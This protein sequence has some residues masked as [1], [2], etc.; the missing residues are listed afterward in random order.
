MQTVAWDQRFGR[1]VFFKAAYLHRNGSHASHRRS[2]S[3][4]RRAHA[5]VDGE[6]KYWELETTGR[7]LA[8]EYRDLTVSY[9]RSHSTRDLNDYDQ[10]F[11][12]FRNP[13][14]RAERELAQPDRRAQPD[15]R[16]RH[17]GPAGKW[18]FSP[19]Y[20]W[21]IGFPVVGR[22]RVSGFRRRAESGRPAAD[23]VDARLLAGPAVEVQEVP[24]QRRHQG[25]QHLQRQG[26]RDVQNN[27]TSPDYGTFY[28]PMQ[29]SIGFAFGSSK[30]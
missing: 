30:P 26:L 21:R 1:R 17:L 8:S 23:R 27:V 7:Y 2:R 20:E 19:L 22:G 4:P 6:S 24:L 14:I 29:R 11:G 15:H 3:R 12:N 18:V 9:V 5:V 13:I 25:L 28:N 16:A 10:F